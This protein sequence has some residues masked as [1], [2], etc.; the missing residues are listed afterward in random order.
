MR[1]VCLHQNDEKS[2][3]KALRSFAEG[4]LKNVLHPTFFSID[5]FCADVYSRDGFLCN[6]TSIP[7]KEE[8]YE[9]WCLL[10]RL[11]H[12][13]N[14]IMDCIDG[15]DENPDIV[16]CGKLILINAAE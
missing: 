11:D 14:G 1:L 8:G 6:V 5:R 16:D 12:V 2:F 9:E 7:I 15:A 10:Y 4:A 13:C 3:L